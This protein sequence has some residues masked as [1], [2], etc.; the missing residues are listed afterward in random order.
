MK[1]VGA[2][3][4]YALSVLRQPELTFPKKM[5]NGLPSTVWSFR[6]SERL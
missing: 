4:I 3:Y 5:F 2:S 1:N 6:R